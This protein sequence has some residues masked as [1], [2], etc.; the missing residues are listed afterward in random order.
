MTTIPHD[1]QRWSLQLLVPEMSR[2]IVNR[3]PPL[4]WTSTS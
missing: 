3:S 4:E 1:K 2:S